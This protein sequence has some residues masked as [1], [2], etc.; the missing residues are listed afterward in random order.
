MPSV[1]VAGSGSSQVTYTS[2]DAVAYATNAANQIASAITKGAAFV[3]FNG[4]AFP[5]TA[6]PSVD[7]FST[8]APPPA[9]AILLSS[10][11]IGV[12]DSLTTALQIQ[13][14]AAGVSVVAGSGGL[15]Y[16]NI[17]ASGTALDNIVAGDG[18]N[19]L[20]TSAAGTGNY[21][22]N[23]G[24][25][26]DTVVVLSGNA[27]INAGTGRNLVVLGGG[28]SSGNS[29]VHS[30]GADSIVGNI[31]SKG[32][33]GSG[34]TDTVNIGSGAVTINPGS[35]NFFVYGNQYNA[36]TVLQ[37]VGSDTVSV[38]RGGG[39]VVGG[40]AGNNY[41]FGGSGGAGSAGTTIR[42]AASGDTLFAIGSGSITAI[43]GAG[44]ELITGAFNPPGFG[45][46]SSTG[47][48]L[49]VAGSGND[50][51]VAGA[52]SDTLV[53]GTGSAQMFAGTGADTFRFSSG[54]GG[55]DTI[56]GFTASSTLQL[57]GFGSALTAANALNTSIVQGGNTVLKL[58]DG[59]TLTF[60][61]GASV[62]NTQIKTS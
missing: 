18:A 14:G 55:A 31:L 44:S 11:A 27:T 39:S 45:S 47:N 19:F 38:G 9:A 7:I 30:E 17:T 20:Q 28:S 61:N 46:T 36:V 16:T 5:A 56:T 6:T 51:L 22:F 52:G 54:T 35:S 58:T 10:T 25:G 4:S 12:I 3:Q 26:N 1:T 34:G 2:N 48:N 24:S 32:T 60:A 57:I 33:A 8:A 21:N 23:T 42:G 49:F 41:L 13:G 50:T 37:G 29:L 15:T 53:G 43:A 40:L 59:T 62:S